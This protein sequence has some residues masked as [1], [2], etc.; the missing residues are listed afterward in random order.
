MLANL[1]P[2]LREIRAPVVSGYLWLAFFFLVLHSDLPSSSHPGKVLQPLFDLFDDLSTL[3]VATVASVAAYLVGSAMQE[4]LK[5]IGRLLSPG[6]PLYAAPGTHI[7]VNGRRSL[8]RSV[9]TQVDRITRR[10]FQVALSPG[11]HGIDD[12][13]EPE[14]VVRELPVVRMQLLGEDPELV[15]ELDRLQAEADLR[16]TVA[17]PLAALAIFLALEASYGWAVG[18]VPAAML[19]VQG[20]QRQREAGDFLA[21][22]LHSGR[23]SA[24]VVTDFE[25][26]VNAALERTDLEWK[27]KGEMAEG[28]GMAAFRYG[29]LLS[30][31]GEYEKAIEPLTAAVK[32][33]VIQAYAELGL[34][35][36]RLEEPEEA[37]RAY[38]DGAERGDRKARSRLAELLRGQQRGEEAL[39]AAKDDSADSASEE[40]ADLDL[41]REGRRLSSYRA[42]ASAGD[43]KAA[44][45]LGMLLQRREDMEGAIQAL[46]RAAELDPEDPSPWLMLARV[47]KKRWHF[48]EARVAIERALALQERKFGSDHLEVAKTVAEVGR[49]FQGLGR[50]HR[51]LELFR[52]ALEVQERELGSDSLEVAL[53]RGGE[54]AALD[55]LGRW[56]EALAAYERALPVV[57]REM[58]EE[59]LAAK[60]MIG[61]LANTKLHLGQL[62]EALELQER[63]LRIEQGSSDAT[64]LGINLTLNNLGNVRCAL[65]EWKVALKLHEDALAEHEGQLGPNALSVAEILDGVGDARMGMGRSEEALAAL[66]RGL[67][68]KEALGVSKLRIALTAARVGKALGEVGEIREALALHE[69]ALALAEGELS[70]EEHPL[71]AG[72]LAE[73]GRLLV[74]EGDHREARARLRQAQ[75]LAEDNGTEYG[76][77][78]VTALLGLGE[79]ELAGGRPD[80]AEAVTAKAIE[81]VEDLYGPTHPLL[82]SALRLWAEARE[83]NGSPEAA[84]SARERA[85]EIERR[86][87]PPDEDPS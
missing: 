55:D 5:L 32:Q 41:P 59:S 74:K 26:S 23:T 77:A 31:A 9:G 35:R 28:D 27:L 11:E 50:D 87:N 38:K 30:S 16:I 63:A 13:P 66:R 45:N 7:S 64:P 43:A 36:E 37:E 81:L 1:L 82:A 14:A 56:S 46:E 34:A 10:L 61:N 20:Y 83:Q 54:A 8:A 79:L 67:G 6:K 3:G 44:L 62:A 18:L 85:T 84:E 60:I 40:T 72:L 15:G 73:H 75:L 49:T 57:E 80:A 58:G 70:T 12:A 24:P 21:G 68:I 17:A 71:I 51:A 42:R 47:Q 76:H 53:T 29:N 86:L 78:H 48:A 52:R 19:L 39:E 4:V 22:V 65:G 33:G 25:I 69:R 2:G